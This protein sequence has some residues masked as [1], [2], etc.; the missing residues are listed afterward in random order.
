MAPALQYF[1]ILFSSLVRFA[2]KDFSSLICAMYSGVLVAIGTGTANSVGAVSKTGFH[3]PA[4]RSLF[5][6]L[7]AGALSVLP[8]ISLLQPINTIV[9]AAINKPERKNIFFILISFSR[10]IR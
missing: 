7:R 9:I 2:W 1:T 6:G 4:F 5:E 3:V 8:T 10:L